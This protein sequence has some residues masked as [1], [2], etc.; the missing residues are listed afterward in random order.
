MT[1]SRDLN[2]ASFFDRIITEMSGNTEAEEVAR[3]FNGGSSEA[4]VSPLHRD[5]Y[6]PLVWIPEPGDDQE[7]AGHTNDEEMDSELLEEEE[8]DKLDMD[9]EMAHESG[10]W[11]KAQRLQ[12]SGPSDGVR[13]LYKSVEFIDDSD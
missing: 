6:T 4:A 1:C 11:D 5:I 13:T 7:V 9:V 10:L 2:K 8:L 3:E 12:A